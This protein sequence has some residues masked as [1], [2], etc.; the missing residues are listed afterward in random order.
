MF[1]DKNE[2]LSTYF[3][4]A[5]VSIIFVLIRAIRGDYSRL[6]R[7]RTFQVFDGLPGND[8]TVAGIRAE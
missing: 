7:Y 2:C 1:H 6:N 8:C 4:L 5:S 3:C